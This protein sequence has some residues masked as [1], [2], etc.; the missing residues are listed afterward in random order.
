MGAR[1]ADGT[2][3]NFSGPAAEIWAP[4]VDI[5]SREIPS[6]FGFRTGTSQAAAVVSGVAARLLEFEPE[7]TVAELKQHLLRIEW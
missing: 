3:A 1:R 7:L 5:W 6:G 4:G 2:R